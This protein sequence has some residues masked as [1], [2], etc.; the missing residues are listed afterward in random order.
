MAVSLFT[1]GRSV[2]SNNFSLPKEKSYA[3]RKPKPKNKIVSPYV[4][5]LN[6]FKK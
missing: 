1:G 4:K 2:K 3:K 6:M 5:Y